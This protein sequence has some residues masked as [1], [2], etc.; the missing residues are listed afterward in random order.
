MN[1]NLLTVARLAVLI[2]YGWDLRHFYKRSSAEE[3]ALIEGLD[4]NAMAELLEDLKRY[5][6]Q[7]VS[8]EYATKIHAELLAVC[9]DEETAQTFIGYA[10]TL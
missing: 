2:K 1:S 9:A 7:L 10:S 3:Q 8:P 4:W 5:H 6:R